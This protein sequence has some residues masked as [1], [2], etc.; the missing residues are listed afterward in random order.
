MSFQEEKPYQER[1][2]LQETDI[3]SEI[4]IAINHSGLRVQ[5]T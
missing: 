3:E 2:T 5:A 4:T 1:G